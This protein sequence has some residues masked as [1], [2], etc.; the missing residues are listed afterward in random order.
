MGVVE[1]I[2]GA[3]ILLMILLISGLVYM[4]SFAH[5]TAKSVGT[6]ENVFFDDSNIN[7]LNNMLKIT[8]PSSGRN[9]GVLL[10]DAVY[11]RNDTLEFNNKSINITERLKE[12][13]NM[14]FGNTQY[15]LE[16]KPRIIE[17]SMNFIIDGSPSLE[18]ERQKLADNLI[19]II[20]NVE[21]KL[22]E[23]N[24]GYKY[25]V[26]MA[27]NPV[28]AHIYVL[29]SKEEKC[30]LFNNITDPKN[31]IKCDV[32]NSNELYLRNATVNTS[33]VFINNTRFNLDA[34]L[35]YYNM[36]PPFG[37]AWVAHNSSYQAPE[38]DYYE[39]DWGYGTAYASNFDDKTTLAHLTLLFPMGDELSTSSI[40]DSCF[41]IP[42]P[43]LPAQRVCVLCEDNCPIN[44]SMRSV[45]KGI[46]VAQDNNHVVNPIFS[47]DCDYQYQYDPF[48]NMMYD[49]VHGNPNGTTSNA[50][51]A[52]DCDGCSFNGSVD[53][54]FHPT[55]RDAIHSQMALMANQ[56]GG[57]IIDLADIATMD[58]NIT[59]TIKKNI[60]QYA[61][62]VGEML[63]YRERDVIET[64]QP[65]PNG[66]LVDVRLWIYKN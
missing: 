49:I 50:C 64:T 7:N 61:L 44:R 26:E 57:K 33:N 15:Y 1:D 59:D 66:E 42:S 48:F 38:S 4:T 19:D 55:C 46:E 35:E 58:V 21:K 63:P 45:I 41:F 27:T 12:L 3:V 54:C 23:T 60:D 36:T 13:L 28:Q 9:M 6:K 29:G 52:P 40:S 53:I 62:K 34:F 2:M 30:D 5:D 24:A 18:Q 37:F 65:L 56:T 14:S 20:K 8:E 51:N 25:K 16:V 17:V 22:N 31:L 39:S 43:N 11:Y 32:I 10:A 47:Y